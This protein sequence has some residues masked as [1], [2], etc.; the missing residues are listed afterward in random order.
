MVIEEQHVEGYGYVEPNY[1]PGAKA[2]A[3]KQ[4]FR[5]DVT[6]GT[7][8]CKVIHKGDEVMAFTLKGADG[9]AKACSSVSVKQNKDGKW[10]IDFAV[11][12]A[13]GCTVGAPLDRTYM[14][15]EL[16]VSY[17]TIN[18]VVI[19]DIEAEAAAAAEAAK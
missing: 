4:D 16:G 15:K 1:T 9:K 6:T 3:G 2:S 7:G 8:T 11:A 19:I 14:F 12:D 17:V 5:V 13:T 18:D 10:E